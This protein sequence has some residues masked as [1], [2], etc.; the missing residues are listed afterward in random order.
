MKVNK[1]WKLYDRVSS[2]QINQLKK[3]LNP[4]FKKEAK[5]NFSFFDFVGMNK[6]ER[7]MLEKEKIEK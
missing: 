1:K 7:E 6:K 5:F 2:D 4:N 3:F